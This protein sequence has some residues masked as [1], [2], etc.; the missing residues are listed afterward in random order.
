MAIAFCALKAPSFLQAEV[1][2]DHNRPVPV[3]P[4]SI[5]YTKAPWNTD[6]TG[7]PATFR[8]VR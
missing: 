2:L 5:A 8:L 7:K 1:K 4:V 3:Q 6:G